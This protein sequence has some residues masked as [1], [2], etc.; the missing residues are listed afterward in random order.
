MRQEY[1][2]STKDGEMYRSFLSI[3]LPFY[4]S[5]NSDISVNSAVRYRD[6]RKFRSLW[7]A[8]HRARFLSNHTYSYYYVFTGER[9]GSFYKMNIV[10]DTIND[11]LKK[12]RKET[13]DKIEKMISDWKVEHGIEQ[14]INE[15]EPR[16]QNECTDT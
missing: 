11:K 9:I 3:P 4:C 14:S 6:A 1:I 12:G 15:S 2:V 13:Q 5:G 8:T 10:N 7:W 16:E